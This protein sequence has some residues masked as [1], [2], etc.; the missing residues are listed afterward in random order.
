MTKGFYEK[1]IEVDSKN[2]LIWFNKGNILFILK[3]YKMAKDFYEY[4]LKV[5]PNIKIDWL[6]KGNFLFD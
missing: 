4:A 6:V 3:K 2:K 1:A 5:D